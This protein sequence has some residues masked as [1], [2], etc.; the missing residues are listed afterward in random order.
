MAFGAHHRTYERV[1]EPWPNNKRK[2]RLCNKIDTKPR[3]NSGNI[4]AGL[5]LS[6]GELSRRHIGRNDALIDTIFS[7]LRR[8]Q[9]IDHALTADTSYDR[10]ILFMQPGVS[11]W[12][13]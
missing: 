9:H 12:C 5:V 4:D 8:Q 6:R 3:I 11:L 7:G 10:V 2:T 13:A 1:I